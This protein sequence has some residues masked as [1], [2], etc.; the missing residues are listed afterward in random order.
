MMIKYNLD[1]LKIMFEV[2]S[3]I[4]VTSVHCSDLKPQPDL[5]LH[6]YLL[7]L[8][9][10]RLDSQKLS[11]SRHDVQDAPLVYGS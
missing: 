10:Q 1:S 9:L 7:N 4:I 11:P 6:I 8:P 5:D 3:H 2:T